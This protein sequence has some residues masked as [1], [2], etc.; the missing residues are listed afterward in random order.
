MSL[1]I[2][3]NGKFIGISW[4]ISIEDY[5]VIADLRLINRNV[6]KMLIKV[7]KIEQV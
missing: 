6:E 1:Q 5:S 2:V 3:G 7:L 4:Y